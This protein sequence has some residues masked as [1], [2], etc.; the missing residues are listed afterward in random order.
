VQTDKDKEKLRGPALLVLDVD[1]TSS[2]NAS[3]YYI[4]NDSG[5]A[6]LKP[7]HQTQA[8]LARVL[9]MCLPPRMQALVPD[10]FDV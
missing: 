7:G 4:V 5:N 8:A 9:L 3:S 2:I 10:A 1:D 6:V